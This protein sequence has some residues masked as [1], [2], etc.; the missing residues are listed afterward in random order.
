MP[1]QVYHNPRI[2]MRLINASIFV[3]L[4][5]HAIKFSDVA[6]F[7]VIIMRMFLIYSWCVPWL[8]KHLIV[9]TNNKL[10]FVLLYAPHVLYSVWFA[11][12]GIS[13]AWVFAL[14]YPIFLIPCFIFTWV[15][16]LRFGGSSIV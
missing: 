11:F 14:A 13:H 8:T 6:S 1:K 2:W 10:W 16:L 5:V 7:E 3:S 12:W 9:K 15:R 4:I